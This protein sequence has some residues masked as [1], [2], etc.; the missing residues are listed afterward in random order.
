MEFAQA[1]QGRYPLYDPSWLRRLHGTC[2][3]DGGTRRPGS[4]FCSVR[5]EE[6][7]AE[8]E[9]SMASHYIGREPLETF[10][11]MEAQ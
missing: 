4:E 7:Y 11:E 6:R 10:L 3:W 9:E 5:C 2:L 1:P 8:W